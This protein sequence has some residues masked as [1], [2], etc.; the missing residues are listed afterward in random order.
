MGRPTIIGDDGGGGGGSSLLLAPA[1]SGFLIGDVL[2]LAGDQ[3]AVE[4]IPEAKR[5]TIRCTAAGVPTGTLIAWPASAAPTGYLLCDGAA[6]SRADYVALFAVI[7]TTY[8][9]G[10]GSTTFNLPDLRGRAP[11]GKDAGQVEFDALGE[12]GGAKAHTL[13]IS[14]MPAHT[15]QQAVRDTI[16]GA[17]TRAEKL[18]TGS[19]QVASAD[20]TAAT[21]GGAAH[22]NLQ[23]YL[24]LQF[25][26]K[27]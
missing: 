20:V 12:T 7:G 16:L 11:V 17:E 22:N 1:G 2:I 8:G 6:V 26:I 5:V 15:H 3:I 4:I 9:V 10:D 25:V 19:G 18:T 14:E 24:V 13:S 21:G 27:T 23:P